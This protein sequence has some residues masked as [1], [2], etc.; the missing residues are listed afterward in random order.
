MLIFFFC[1]VLATVASIQSDRKD[2]QER[3]KFS[4]KIHQK[5]THT[6]SSRCFR[7]PP[8]R[9][10]SISRDDAA[11]IHRLFFAPEDFFFFFTTARRP[12]LANVVVCY[13]PT[14]LHDCR[15]LHVTLSVA[16][17]GRSVFA[18]NFHRPAASKE[19]ARLKG[20]PKE[21]KK[22]TFVWAS[23]KQKMLLNTFWVATPL[24]NAVLSHKSREDLLWLQ[25]EFR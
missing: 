11:Y 20:K 4:V 6:H 15:D 7:A 25:S 9:E 17:R 16:L 8:P 13:R 18:K 14:S 22:R 2:W 1:C 10:S 24:P 12:L 21:K 23:N 19:K 5:R 3:Q